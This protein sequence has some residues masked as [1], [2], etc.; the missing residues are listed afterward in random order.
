MATYGGKVTQD[1]FQQIMLD[2]L[3]QQPKG[4]VNQYLLGQLNSLG[5][6]NPSAAGY[7]G[8][9]PS[10]FPGRSESWYGNSGN[11]AP[12]LKISNPWLQQ[13]TTTTQMPGL[14]TSPQQTQG[15]L[16]QAPVNPTPT[17][18]N[19]WAVV[20][21]PN[22]QVTVQPE[23]QTPPQVTVQPP[24]QN[25]PQVNPPV[26]TAP[27]QPTPTAPQPTA[28]ELMTAEIAKFK[29]TVVAGGE[30]KYMEFL[31]QG[32]TPAEAS[33]QANQWMSRP[34]TSAGNV[35]DSGG[36]YK[37]SL[38]W[39]GAEIDYYANKIT[40]L[41]YGVQGT[42]KRVNVKYIGPGEQYD[43]GKNAVFVGVTGDPHQRYVAK[44]IPTKITNTQGA[45]EA[46]MKLLSE[47]VPPSEAYAQIQSNAAQYK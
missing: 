17:P 1:N 4:Q 47:G 6:T 19:I 8:Q 36:N 39:S 20:N 5:F 21:Q 35:S 24:V 12:Q 2:Q 3:R 30:G 9:M 42:T 29:A 38:P 23:P 14:L 26:N 44:L 33:A 40:D 13:N 41:T 28:E 15:G 34:S 10:V 45:S 22:P 32:L 18:D 16:L 11:T 27:V 43:I 25:Q 46:Y 37:A 31:Q 7:P